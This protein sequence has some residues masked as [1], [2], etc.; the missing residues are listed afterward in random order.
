MVIKH[1]YKQ[2]KI[3]N[4]RS[5]LNQKTSRRPKDKS[6][7]QKCIIKNVKN[8]YDSKQKLVYLII[9]QELDQKPFTKQNEKS[10]KE[11][12]HRKST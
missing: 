5:E 2:K 9:I 11:K 3:E 1:Y 7:N 10:N 8:I 12:N 6:D 4:I